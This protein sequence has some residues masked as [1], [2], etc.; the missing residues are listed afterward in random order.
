MCNASQKIEN[1]IGVIFVQ[2]FRYQDKV[3]GFLEFLYTFLSNILSLL[4]FF[5]DL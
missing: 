5:G 3:I 1:E 4:V 2:Y